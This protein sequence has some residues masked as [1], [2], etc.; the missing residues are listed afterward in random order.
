MWNR[1]KECL[2]RPVQVSALL[3]G[4]LVFVG[5]AGVVWMWLHWME[6]PWDTLR[7]NYSPEQVLTHTESKFWTL[8]SALG[9]TL[10]ALAVINKI[11]FF[12]TYSGHHHKLTQKWEKEDQKDP[13]VAWHAVE[14]NRA[15]GVR[16]SLPGACFDRV[17]AAV[18]VLYQIGG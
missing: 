4:L 5:V 16:Y 3:L 18:C 11:E 9:L 2:Q 15:Y 14:A 17:H 10:L 6:V 13:P 12:F 8:L 1:I 7:S